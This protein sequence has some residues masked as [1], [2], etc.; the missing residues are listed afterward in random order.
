V[1]EIR[2][3]KKVQLNMGKVVGL[4]GDHASTAAGDHASVDPCSRVQS[5]GSLYPNVSYHPV[6]GLVAL[7]AG[8]GNHK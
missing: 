5:V 7:F 8:S 6:P 2:S 1:R 4:A 3:S